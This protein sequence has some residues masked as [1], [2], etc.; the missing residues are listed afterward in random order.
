MLG[1]LRS[2][3]PM[4]PE[5]VATSRDYLSQIAEKEAR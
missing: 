5:Q 4:T 1:C 2:F 3:A